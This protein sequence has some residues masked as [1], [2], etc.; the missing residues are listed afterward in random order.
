[1]PRGTRTDAHFIASPWENRLHKKTGKGKKSVRGSSP[2][3]GGG[4]FPCLYPPSWL[5]SNPFAHR[6][7]GRSRTWALVRKKCIS[8]RSNA[9]W[10]EVLEGVFHLLKHLTPAAA[11]NVSQ[12]DGISTET[13][14]SAARKQIITTNGS[15]WGQA[16][17]KKHSYFAWRAL[18]HS[19]P[20]QNKMLFSHP[21]GKSG[22]SDE[23]WVL[24]VEGFI[25]EEEEKQGGEGK[26]RPAY[27]LFKP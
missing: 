6:G 7:V 4:L 17:Q 15:G 26:H 27:A 12:T 21:V 11:G 9:H 19:C 8:Q 20:Y 24:F 1:M 14:V 13:S 2:E 25:W 3:K 23:L 18:F 5:R 10:G 16:S 22:C